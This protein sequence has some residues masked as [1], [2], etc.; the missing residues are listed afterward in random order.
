MLKWFNRHF[1]PVIFIFSALAISAVLLTGNQYRLLGPPPPGTDQLSMLKAAV[2]MYQGYMPER[3][4]LYSP[5]YTVFLY[6]LV[7]LTKGQLLLMMLLQ[8]IVCALTPVFV[9]K[10]CRAVRMRFQAAQLAA[11][12]LCFY[13][14]FALLA[15]TPLREAPLGLCFLLYVYLLV[16]GYS[17]KSWW[18]IALAG[19][20]GG[21]CILGRETFVP[22][23]GVPVLL[24]V[25]KD[26][27]R[28]I[29]RKQIM[30]YVGAVIAVLLPVMLYNYIRFDSPSIIPGHFNNILG[31]FHG[32][33]ALGDRSVAVMSIIR[34]IP[35]Q[36][37]LFL[38]SYEYDNSVSVYAHQEVILPLRLMALPYN[39]LPG[40]ALLSL[41]F[42][43]RNRGIILIALMALGYAATMLYFDLYYRYRFPVVPVLIALS[44]P[45]L[46]C[47]LTRR[48]YKQLAPPL[49]TVL[50]VFAL[51]WDSPA[52]MRRHQ[53]RYAVVQ[54]FIVNRM[55]DRAEEYVRQLRREGIP[56][57][58]VLLQLMR[59]L[60][61]DG[62]TV[63]AET[64]YRES[65]RLDLNGN[66]E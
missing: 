40:L 14:P 13:A 59:A 19:M 36:M 58:G 60:H 5:S 50:V 41:W 39:L 46:Y 52:K 43:R 66:K 51:T 35:H 53:E 34:N 64:L 10:L 65:Q 18:K 3:G 26:L 22:V 12:L 37:Y 61:G 15:V 25:F 32:D 1:S 33:K 48:T 55:Y 4:Y 44:G 20:F 56:V 63:R 54:V 7:L 57:R 42:F 6:V 24:Q 45:G 62:Q 29:C 21:L 23:M 16:R 49:L 9:Y 27:R 2:G 11:L 8:G 28:R 47:L 31:S 30:A 38:S 17:S